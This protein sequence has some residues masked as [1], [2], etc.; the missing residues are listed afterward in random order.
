MYVCALLAGDQEGSRS[1][2]ERGVP[3]RGG[4]G[5]HGREDPRRDQ[6]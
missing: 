1:E 6:K 4:R 3:V 2:V 5:P